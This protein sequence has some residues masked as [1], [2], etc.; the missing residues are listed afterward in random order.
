MSQY[1]VAWITHPASLRHEMG[2]GHP[3][4]PARLQAIED[5]LLA[6][7]LTPLF[8]QLRAP[9]VERADL[10]RVHTK[11]L[12]ERVLSA[13]PSEGSYLQIDPDTAMNAHSSEAAQHAAG[14]A[15][16]AVDTVLADRAELAFC[17]VRP[18]GHHAERARSMGFCLFNNIAV[19]AAHAL[20]AGLSRV[21]ILDFDVH[22]GNGTADIFRDDPRVLLCSTY[23]DPLYP[24]WRADHGVAHLLDVALRPGAG[25]TEYRDAVEHHWLPA[26][27]TFEPQLLLVSA[28]FD[29]HAADPL[30]GL[31]LQTA[32]FGWTAEQLRL[33]AA[34]CCQGRIVASLEGGYEVHALARSVEAFVRPFV[35]A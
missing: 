24:Y 27:R 32:D 19:A 29:A 3:E 4:S 26:L 1:A 23:Q 33:V 12:I 5:R 8:D 13:H 28:G 7:G 35:V 34:E 6:A 21:A 11:A 20:A 2:A 16:L 15:V 25:S 30:A 18:P 14:A 17:A 22:Y 9:R 31:S 10:E